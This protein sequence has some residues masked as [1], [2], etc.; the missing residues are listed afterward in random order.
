MRVH[1]FT[2]LFATDELAGTALFTALALFLRGA[3]LTRIRAAHMQMVE[4]EKAPNSKGHANV[5]SD[6]V[7]RP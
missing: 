2:S 5:V 7:A 3:D 4:R 6:C 1:I